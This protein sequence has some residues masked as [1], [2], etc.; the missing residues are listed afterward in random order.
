MT[1]W[2]AFARQLELPTQEEGSLPTS[3]LIRLAASGALASHADSLEF[4]EINRQLGASSGSLRTLVTVH[5]MALLALVRRAQSSLVERWR[6][7]LEAGSKFAAFAASEEGAGTRLD[8]V[9]CRARLDETGYRLSGTK[10]WVSFGQ[11]ADA[12]LVLARAPGGLTTFWVSR[13]QEGL[14]VEPS[15]P[16]A[17]LQASLSASVH[18]DACR[19]EANQLVG[20]EGLGLAL[21]VQE[22]LTLGRL[23]VAWGCLGGLEAC[24]E[25]S[26]EHVRARGLGEHGQ[27]LASLGQ[28]RVEALALEGLARRASRAWQEREPDCA[29]LAMAAKFAAAASYRRAAEVAV[30]LQGGV[31]CLLS[32]PLQRHLR[33]SKVM[34]IIEGSQPVLAAFLGKELL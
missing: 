29:S 1:D 17:G 28:M 31:G 14:R 18:F 20:G 32:N 2:K 34:E 11:I 26:I 30:C 25:S 24:L 33:D 7:P 8:R 6:G 12:F 10:T 27:V 4:A 16:L 5:S 23:G 15:E 21:V 3:V 22:C 9:R 19:V 13:E